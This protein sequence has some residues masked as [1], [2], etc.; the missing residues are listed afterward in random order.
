MNIRQFGPGHRRAD[1]AAGSNG[2]LSSAIFSND[3]AQITEFTVTPGGTYGPLRSAGDVVLVVI[4]GGGW[5]TVLET[6]VQLAA[7]ESLHLERLT[8][9]SIAARE[10]PLRAILVELSA[11][12]VTES[13]RTIGTSGGGAEE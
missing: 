1:R 10:L 12:S 5:V 9:Y 13:A 2:V 7:G 11:S 3:I 8:P 6:L 4:E